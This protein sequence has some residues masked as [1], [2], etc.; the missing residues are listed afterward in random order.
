MSPD[1]QD[2][3]VIWNYRKYLRGGFLTSEAS[4]LKSDFYT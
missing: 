1:I 4:L 2:L 3:E